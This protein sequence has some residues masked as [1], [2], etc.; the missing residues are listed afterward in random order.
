VGEDNVDIARRSLEEFNR[1][2]LDALLGR[3]A[4]DAE[5]YSTDALPN[6]GLYRGREGYLA[7]VGAWLDAWVDFRVEPLSFEPIGDR[8]V[9]VRVRQR[10]RGRHSGVEIGM[11]AW[12]LFELRGASLRRFSLYAD[13]ASAAAAIPA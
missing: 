1:G 5:V 13:R 3:F 12:Y 4:D 8:Y 9:L 7:W 11:D 10:G 2:D 6:G